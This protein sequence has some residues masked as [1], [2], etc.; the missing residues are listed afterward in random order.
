MEIYRVIIWDFHLGEHQDIKNITQ[1]RSDKQAKIIKMLI[2]LFNKN[3][4]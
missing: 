1:M 4:L 2:S 3:V